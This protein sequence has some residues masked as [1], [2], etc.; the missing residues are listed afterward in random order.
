MTHVN[1]CKNTIQCNI[2]I[3]IFFK[4]AILNININY[5]NYNFSKQEMFAFK[6]TGTVCLEAVADTVF[7]CTY[8]LIPIDLNLAS[9]H[10]VLESVF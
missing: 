4:G 5:Y 3:Y 10:G 8:V 2:Y 9:D 1:I 6:N 7:M